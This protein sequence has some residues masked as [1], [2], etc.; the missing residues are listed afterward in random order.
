MRAM[1]TIA[2]IRLDN[3]RLLVQE[4][5]SQDAVAVRGNTSPVYISQ[6]INQTPDS[7]TK[8][9]RQIGDPL[10]RKLE[11][12]CDKELGWMDNHHYD[13]GR[14]YRIEHAIAAMEQMRDWQF[15]QAIKILD[16]I[17][18]PQPNDGTTGS[19]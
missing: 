8:K 1:R 6:V 7:K 19:A 3:L 17:A 5:G 2:Q 14:E 11:A 16:T 4:F 10:A 12:G 13:R 15:D 18:Q 9:P